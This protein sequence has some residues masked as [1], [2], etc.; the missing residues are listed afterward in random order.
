ML[1]KAMVANSTFKDL[2]DGLHSNELAKVVM[3]TNSSGAPIPLVT[4]NVSPGRFAEIAWSTCA[5][6][7][8]ARPDFPKFEHAIFIAAHSEAPEYEADNTTGLLGL[9]QTRGEETL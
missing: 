8:K 2:L 6:I 7:V 3:T 5:E 4:A 1:M 9:W